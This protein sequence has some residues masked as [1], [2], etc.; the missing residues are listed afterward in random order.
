MKF[1]PGKYY[2]TR[3]GRKARYIGR[4]FHARTKGNDKLLFE[5]K[6]FSSK[7]GWTVRSFLE[8]GR[9]LKDEENYYDIVSEW[10]DHPGAI[11]NNEITKEEGHLKRIFENINKHFALYNRSEF[12]DPFCP[13]EDDTCI[14]PPCKKEKPKKIDNLILTREVAQRF[15]VEKKFMHSTN[16]HLLDIEKKINQLID[17][18]NELRNK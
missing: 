12:V 6:L 4:Y 1:I 10:C 14:F 7:E 2:K 16:M 13:C 8:N 18:V 11:G 15:D 3:D 5:V 9:Y 17:A